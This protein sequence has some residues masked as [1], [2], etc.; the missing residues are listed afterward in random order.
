MTRDDIIRM[1]READDYADKML[2]VGEFHPDWHDVRDEHFAALVAA[3]L[4]EK[5]KELEYQLKEA[6]NE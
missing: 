6:R 3:T 2:G 4:E 5:I 1:A